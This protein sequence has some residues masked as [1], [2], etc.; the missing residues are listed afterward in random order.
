MACHSTEMN[1]SAKKIS[2]FIMP[3]YCNDFHLKINDSIVYNSF[4]FDKQ[5][6][7]PQE[8]ITTINKDNKET[9]KIDIRIMEKDTSFLYNVKNVDSLIFGLDIKNKYFVIMNQSQYVWCYD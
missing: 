2:L 1:K 4:V 7:G 9:L 3:E 8:L 5:P 6:H